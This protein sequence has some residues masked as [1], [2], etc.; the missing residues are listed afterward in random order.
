MSPGSSKPT[1]GPPSPSKHIS[2]LPDYA[3]YYRD[4]HMDTAKG[5]NTLQSYSDIRMATAKGNH[6]ADDIRMET[7]R[8]ESTVKQTGFQAWERELLESTEVKRKATVAQL[9][10]YLVLESIS[11]SLTG[12][13]HNDRLLGLLFPNIRVHRQ[14]EGSACKVRQGHELAKS[15]RSRISK[16][17][18]VVLRS[19]TRH[20]TKA[21]D[22][23][24]SRSISYH[25]TSR[26]RRI[27]GGVFGEKAGFGRG[28]CPQEDEETHFIQDGRGTHAHPHPPNP[29][30]VP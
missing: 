11:Q 5:L 9:C 15:Q 2:G 12:P 10:E 4:V 25:R 24:Q 1:A 6:F 16:R 3:S 29:R 28:M 14:P 18:Q 20:S 21:A 17:I 8:G 13:P 19:G 23:T 30:G 27:W 26:T 7:A 22:E